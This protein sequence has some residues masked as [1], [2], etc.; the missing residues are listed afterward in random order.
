MAS[1]QSPFSFKITQFEKT[2]W[3]MKLMFFC[4]LFFHDSKQQN[5]IQI[6]NHSVNNK[7]NGT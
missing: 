4:F 6:V 1:K 5:G 3:Y 7:Q 2:E